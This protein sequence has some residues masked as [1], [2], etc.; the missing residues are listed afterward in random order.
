MSVTKLYSEQLEGLGRVISMSRTRI[1][2]FAV[3]A[4]FL[5]L[6]AIVSAYLAY[7][8]LR[9][10]AARLA[11]DPPLSLRSWMGGVTGPDDAQTIVLKAGE[12]EAAADREYAALRKV[13]ED[14]TILSKEDNRHALERN[15][16]DDVIDERIF[17]GEHDD[18]A[19]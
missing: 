1:L 18:Y 2:A 10:H 12:E 14:V 3:M 13:L 15:D 8:T 16:P 6:I 4:A 11:A 19:R 17:V 5:A 7:R 9:T